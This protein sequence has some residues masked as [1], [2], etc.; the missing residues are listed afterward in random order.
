MYPF[1]SRMFFTVA[2]MVQKRQPLYPDPCTYDSL[3]SLKGGYIGD[4]IGEQKRGL[5]RGILG[6]YTFFIY[7]LQNSRLGLYRP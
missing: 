4:Q 6:G 7:V 3:N 2:H 5:Q 1:N